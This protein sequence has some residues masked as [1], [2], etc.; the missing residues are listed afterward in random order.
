MSEFS[1][2]FLLGWEHIIS[3][4]ALDHL[5]F[6]T[7]LAVMYTLKDWKASLILVTAFTVGHSITL[8]LSA[9]NLIVLSSKWVEFS[10]ACT[11]ITASVFNIFQLSSTKKSIGIKYFLALFFGLIHGLGFANTLRFLLTDGDSFGWALFGFNIGLECG[12]LLIVFALL[13]IATLLI[14]IFQL[15]QKHWVIVVSLGIFCVALKMAIERLPVDD[16]K[17][18]YQ[19]NSKRLNNVYMNHLYL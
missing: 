3:I 2:Y 1:F 9:S 18:A 14:Q 6:I 11:I 12:Q 15:K 10:I 4:D 19:M 16:N 7:S 8:A 5:L 17:N 13:L